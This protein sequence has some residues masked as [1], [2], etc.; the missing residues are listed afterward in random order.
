[1]TKK[2]R[3]EFDLNLETVK[4]L[5]EFSECKDQPITDE[6]LKEISEKGIIRASDYLSQTDVEDVFS[7][8]FFGKIAS[9]VGRK[10]V[11]KISDPKVQATVASEVVN[12]ISVAKTRNPDDNPRS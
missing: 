10:L 6:E 11:S 1:M 7:A 8:G 12:T 5:I 2:I 4:E 3:V 9:K